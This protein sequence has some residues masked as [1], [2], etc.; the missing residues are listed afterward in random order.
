VPP[1]IADGGTGGSLAYCVSGN[2]LT[3]GPAPGSADEGEGVI[4]LTK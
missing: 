3:W 4:V 1:G 2:T